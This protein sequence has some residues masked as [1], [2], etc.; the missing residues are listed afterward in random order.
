MSSERSINTNKQII[1]LVVVVSL[2]TQN[3]DSE[4]VLLHFA[5]IFPF[6]FKF[7]LLTRCIIISINSMH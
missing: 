6:L 4:T 7:K 2:I 5:E 3:I 1:G